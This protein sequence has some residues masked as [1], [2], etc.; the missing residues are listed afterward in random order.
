MTV[1]VSIATALFSN[2]VLSFRTTHSSSG[3]PGNV[4]LYFVDPDSLIVIDP[5]DVRAPLISFTR[6]SDVIAA[7][8]Y[9]VE[10]SMLVEY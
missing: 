2:V 4:V 10:F 3:A 1:T 9:D 7:R 8:K 5:K 6:S